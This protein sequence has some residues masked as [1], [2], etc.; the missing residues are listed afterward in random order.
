MELWSSD[1]PGGHSD[2]E[3]THR[4]KRH[5]RRGLDPWVKK[6]WRRKWQP[7]LV[8]LGFPC[9]SAGKESTCNV[10]DLGLIPGLEKSPGEGKGYPLHYS[11]LENSMDC[12]VQG[13]A[14]SWTWLSD[15]H[16]HFPVFLPGK[17][18]WTEEPGRLHGF[19]KSWTQLSNWTQHSTHTVCKSWHYVGLKFLWK[20]WSDCTVF[21]S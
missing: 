15:F 10:G 11:G 6:I 20:H 5:K 18:P 1:F 9:G 4:C 12:I 7:T 14:K 19:A 21:K 16:L 2:K 3:S 17:F 13:V 8:F